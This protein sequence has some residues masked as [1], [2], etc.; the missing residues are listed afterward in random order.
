MS[1]KSGQI[2]TSFVD[3]AFPGSYQTGQTVTVLWVGSF[4][5]SFKPILPLLV[6]FRLLVFIATVILRVLVFKATVEL[7][8]R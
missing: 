5:E 8:R 4:L 6:A 2:K 7:G 1:I 3:K